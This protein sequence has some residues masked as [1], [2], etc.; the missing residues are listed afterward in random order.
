MHFSICMTAEGRLNL[1]TFGVDSKYPGSAMAFLALQ[2]E[3]CLMQHR[4]INKI[5]LLHSSVRTEKERRV[6]W[7]SW[8]ICMQGTL[9]SAVGFSSKRPRVPQQPNSIFDCWLAARSQRSSGLLGAFPANQSSP[10]KTEIDLLDFS[11]I[12]SLLPERFQICPPR[13]SK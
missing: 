10:F 4:L 13:I 2:Q 5:R 8:L 3:F 9:Q 1:R 12:Y 6:W 11:N 7:Y